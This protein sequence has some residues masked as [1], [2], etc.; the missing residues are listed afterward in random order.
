MQMQWQPPLPP[1]LPAPA[2]SRWLPA[3]IVAA[4][5]LIAAGLV[6]GALILKDKDGPTTCQAWSETRLTLRAIPALPDGWNW[7]T[8]NITTLI[9]N[10]NTPVGTAL[11]L[12]EPKIEPR[13][14]DLAQAAQAYVAAKREQMAAL[15]DRSYVPADGQKVDAALDRLNQLCGIPGSGQSI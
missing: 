12:F 5:A 8:P 7:N 6:A 15:A 1:P 11:D 4:A 14:A 3:A 2:R 13:P 9:K 10:Q